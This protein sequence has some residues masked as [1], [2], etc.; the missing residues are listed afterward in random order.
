MAYFADRQYE[1]ALEFAT[2]A[3]HANPS[4]SGAYKLL[5]PALVLAGRTTDARH[6]A[7]NLLRL[8]PNLTVQQFRHSS[9]GGQGEIGE[10]L[11]EGLRSAGIP[12]S[13]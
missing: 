8:E 12:G 3:I 11:C 10:R 7:N 9:P 4:Y 1:R 2:R 6:A 13:D 5:V